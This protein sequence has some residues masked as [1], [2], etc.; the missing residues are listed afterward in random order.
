MPEYMD[1]SSTHLRARIEVSCATMGQDQRHRMLKRTS[2]FFTG[3]VYCS[4][5][6]EELGLGEELLRTLKLWEIVSEGLPGNLKAILAPYGAMVRYEKSG[7]LNGLCHESRK[8]LCW[9]AQPEIYKLAMSMRKALA[10]GKE[11][12]HILCLF[13]PPCYATGKC[14][15]AK[16]CGRDITLR[17]DEK[18]FFVDRKV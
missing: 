4:N 14:G 7:D 1:N 12:K 13:E 5:I 10:E 8:R 15:E 11:S 18:K 3:D 16:S 6:L 9:K 2:P 17:N